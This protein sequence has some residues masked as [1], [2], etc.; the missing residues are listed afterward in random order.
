MSLQGPAWSA[1]EHEIRAALRGD[2]FVLH[3]QPICDA[4]SREVIAYESLVRWAHPLHGMIPPND[5]IPATETTGLIHELGLWVVRRACRDVGMLQSRY[6]GVNVSAVQLRS[7]AFA[8][9]FASTI[10]KAGVEP[11]RITVEITES[12]A[13]EEGGIERRNLDAIRRLGCYLAIDDF[14]TGFAS[15]NYIEKFPFNVLKIDKSFVRDVAKS[16]VSRDDVATICEIGRRHGMVIVAEG[17]ET[18]EQLDILRDIGCSRA[19][20]YLLGRP[21]PL[22]RTG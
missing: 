21:A 2:N 1:T 18:Q 6:V 3:Y 11:M 16:S 5:F 14:G 22:R 17:V 7:E 12:V 20:G 9:D 10:E 8:T 15:Y 4:M 19:Q 13:L